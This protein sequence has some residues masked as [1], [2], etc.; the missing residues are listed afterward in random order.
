M[1]KLRTLQTSNI[2]VPASQV[3]THAQIT[4]QKSSSNEV[5]LSIDS[6]VST[7]SAVI[8]FNQEKINKRDLSLPNTK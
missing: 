7:K 3:T 8:V 6:K 2:S 1:S 4:K 5:L